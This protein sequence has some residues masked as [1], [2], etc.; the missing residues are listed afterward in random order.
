[1]ESKPLVT[2][3]VPTYNN[4]EFLFEALDSIF[5]QTYNNIELIIS[6][7]ASTTFDK[8]SV[9][10]YIEKNSKNNLTNY[11]VLENEI[12][13][14]TTKHF[15]SIIAKSSGK[16]ILFLSCDDLFFDELV[17]EKI[18]S[19]FEKEHCLIATAFRE[20]YTQDLKN[21]VEK[22]PNAKDLTYLAKKPLA[23]YNRLCF[24]NFISGACTYY[25]RE[26]IEKYQLFD[27]TYVLL[28]D[29]P[30]Y[31]K[32]SRQEVKIAFMSFTTIKYRLG[33]VS[34]NTQNTN[35]PRLNKDLA[36]IFD[37]EIKPYKHLLGANY[38]FLKIL[39]LKAKLSIRKR[40]KLFLN[41]FIKDL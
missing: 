38:I 19:F 41:Y 10:A 24:G 21:L 6:D 3:I 39:D 22:V 15:N 14:G 7:D 2:C 37:K 27:E 26:L 13:L 28:E 34:T 9:I 8:A 23:L 17:I 32:L 40:I 20:V 4:T 1:M 31:L 30:S 16:Y 25:T 11:L 35:S 12:N 29:Y 33:G 18:V 5:I 36:K